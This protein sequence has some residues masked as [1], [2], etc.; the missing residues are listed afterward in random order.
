MWEVVL[1]RTRRTLTEARGDFQTMICTGDI[2]LYAVVALLEAVEALP[3]TRLT[4]FPITQCYL[5][6]DG[7]NW[8]D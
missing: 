1:Y 3:T 6:T 7:T 8:S 4:G 5:C 2:P